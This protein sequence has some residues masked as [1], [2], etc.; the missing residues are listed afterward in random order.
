MS[1]SVILT[2][3]NGKNS[4]VAAE[5]LRKI[6][7]KAGVDVSLSFFGSVNSNRGNH[8]L[9]IVVF[10][11]LGDNRLPDLVENYLLERR[12]DGRVAL[13]LLGDYLKNSP[14][15]CT[16]AEEALRLLAQRKIHCFW[17]PLLLDTP[18]D[19]LDRNGEFAQIWVN[20]FLRDMPFINRRGVEFSHTYID[21]K[22][23]ALSDLL[24]LVPGLSYK[25]NS[26][27]YCTEISLSSGAGYS[28]SVVAHVSDRQMRFI[29]SLLD[30][31]EFLTV[32]KLPYLGLNAWPSNTPNLNARLKKIDLR[33]NYFAA[34]SFLGE[35]R[36]LLWLNIG[37]NDLD[38]L[39]PDV[40][41][42]ERLRVLLA[43]KNRIRVIGGEI[44]RLSALR[45][46]SLYRNFIT[47]IP[48]EI[49]RCTVLSRLNIGAN[50]LVS[51]PHNISN[52][53]SLRELIMR[54]SEID[55]FLVVIESLKNLN[56]LDISK[57][58]LSSD[59]IQRLRESLS[60]TRIISD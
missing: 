14:G 16:V 12:I 44:G 25:L 41:G 23:A 60:L 56:I 38:A 7:V 57:G 28:R 31:L 24:Y 6:L 53:L 9:E 43:Y 27:G 48:V 39:P 50:P 2:T 5:M 59:S 46:L 4:S 3:W 40:F 52:L 32:L 26:F 37:D 29:W 15:Q 45:R 51:V 18:F 13:C 20:S 55:R 35:F 11:I 10:P 42:L 47:E 54:N 22:E 30:R 17:P 58:R 34:Y 21:N 36:N 19:S 8:P 49:L 1:E 33:G